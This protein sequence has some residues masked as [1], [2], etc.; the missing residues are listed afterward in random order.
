MNADAF[1]LPPGCPVTLATR[2][3]RVGDLALRWPVVGPGDVRAVAAY[4][5]ERQAAVLARRS[6]DDI[7]RVL[8]R[9][10]AMWLEETEP[11]RRLALPAISAV[12]G[13]SEPMVAHA[14]DLE[15]RSSRRPDLLGALDRELGDH[16]ALDGFVQTVGGRTRAFGPALVGGIFSANIPAL[17]HLT[18][19]R[20]FLVKAAC[21]GR[22]SRGEPVYLPLYAESLHAIDA[23]LASCLAVL[24][25]PSDDRDV[26]ASFLESID[27][28]IAY[29]GDRALRDLRSRLPDGVGST[30]HGHRMGFA[31]VGRDVT[32][33]D[34]VADAVAYDF[35]V[36]DQ[37]ACLAP[38][39]CYV[40]R[41][42]GLDA[43]AESVAAAMERW[44]EKLPPRRIAPAEAAVLRSARDDL[45]LR[46]AMG[47]PVRVLT[48]RNRLQ[49][50][51]AVIPADALVPTPLDR[52]CRIVPVDGED[53]LIRCL[54]PVRRYLQCAAVAGVSDDVRERLAALGVTRLCAPGLMGTPS[55]L[56][57]HDGQPCLGRLV[58]WCDE[59][60][61]APPLL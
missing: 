14:I 56:W 19:L 27:H 1:W 15:Q 47:E 50:T 41:A 25:W 24:H 12:T 57:A 52:S 10:A 2:E 16:R 6:I 9:A 26:E 17:P 43:F 32:D 38:Q 11:L 13:F 4:L 40:D 39:A 8:D 7:A 20:S 42:V 45:E 28:L 61:R 31:Y 44:L 53:E 58:R 30:W 23:D 51:V 18:V 34:A 49:G 29:G 37:H 36:F 48:P 54:E 33:L 35:T 60:S 22:V 3:E 5:R 46:E 55:M 21:L 59:E